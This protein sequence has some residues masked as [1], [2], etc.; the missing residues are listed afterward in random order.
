ML[1]LDRTSLRCV[2]RRFEICGFGVGRKDLR[3]ISILMY[4][5]FDVY[6]SVLYR[7]LKNKTL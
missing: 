6:R 7:V 2:L 5:V 4:R 3:M 1:V